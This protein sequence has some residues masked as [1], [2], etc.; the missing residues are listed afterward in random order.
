MATSE[1]FVPG[2]ISGFFQVH[3]SNNLSRVGSRN[4]GPCIDAGVHTKTRAEESDFTDIEI[5][6]NGQKREADST[7]MGVEEL[8]KVSG[9]KANIKIEHSVKAPIGA[10]Y[11]MSGAGTLGAVLSLSNALALDIGADRILSIAHRAEVACKSGLGDVGPQ[12]MG[13]FIIGLEAGGPP[14]GKWKS[15]KVSEDIKFVCGTS[16]LLPTSDFLD[17]DS[18]MKR[19]I[20]LG[21]TALKNLL[22]DP[23]LRSF[24]RVSKDFALDLNIFE[25]DFIEVLED[26]SIN[27][28]LGASAVMLGRAIF[29]PVK[30][31]EVEA[32]KELFLDYFDHRSVFVTSVDF[33]GARILP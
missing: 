14:F 20:S 25:E 33:K 16:G 12:M 7:K 23:N 22:S 21:G 17:N 30:P 6:I 29:A 3:R 9:R 31:S 19:S 15:M 10:G 1:V 5:T 4:C 28:P 24:M 18:F 26:I 11:G 32:I 2:H 27:S 8:L 13:G